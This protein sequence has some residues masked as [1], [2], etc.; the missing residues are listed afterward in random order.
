MITAVPAAVSCAVPMIAELKQYVAVVVSQKVTVPRVTGE[1]LLTV[2]VNVTA[3]SA[4]TEDEDSASVVVVAVC[5]NAAGT[6]NT[7]STASVAARRTHPHNNNNKEG[8]S[9]SRKPARNERLANRKGSE[10]KILPICF[11]QSSIHVARHSSE[12]SDLV[13]MKNRNAKIAFRFSLCCALRS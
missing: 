6:P 7:A 8:R 1:P 12:P 11:N 3:V 4:V 9:A 5:P 2:A 10:F 13:G